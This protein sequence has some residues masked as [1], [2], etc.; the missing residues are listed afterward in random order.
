[1]ADDTVPGSGRPVEKASG[2]KSIPSWSKGS[3]SRSYML[4]V[5]TAILAVNQLDRH[6]LNISLDAIGREFSLFLE[7]LQTATGSSVESSEGSATGTGIGAALLATCE[8]SEP[9]AINDRSYVAIVA[10]TRLLNYASTW[11]ESVR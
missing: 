11:R 3:Q 7:M 2:A 9:E 6:I 5:L 8:K 4:M 1:M 10:D